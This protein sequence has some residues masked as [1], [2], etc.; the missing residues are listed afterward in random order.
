MDFN[1][2]ASNISISYDY[3]QRDRLPATEDPRWSRC[4]YRQD[5]SS[6]NEDFRGNSNLR[7]CYSYRYMQLDRSGRDFFTDSSI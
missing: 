6:E 4:D 1:G 2:G 3:Y 5:V 7:N